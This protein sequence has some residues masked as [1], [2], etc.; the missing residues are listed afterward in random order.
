MAKKKYSLTEEHRAQLKP[1]ADK[2]IKNAMS[3]EPMTEVDR[4]TCREAVKGLYKAAKLQPPA[5]HNIVFVSSPFALRF[6]GGF[7]AA[8]WYNRKEK[9]NYDDP[10]F[11]SYEP[12][13]VYNSV[14]TAV[15]NATAIDSEKC[16]FFNGGSLTKKDLENKSKWYKWSSKSMKNLSK[17]LGLGETK[18]MCI[19]PRK[20]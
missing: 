17:D 15:R 5:D 8:I 12:T 7:A 20:H 14:E 2:W 16:W 4:N 13:S 3:T 1:W 19:F 18:I 9:N 10:K 11:S 6:A